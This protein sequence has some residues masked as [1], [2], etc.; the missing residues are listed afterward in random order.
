MTTSLV[1]N[2][3]ELGR[4]VQNHLNNGWT[5]Y[6]SLFILGLV[7]ITAFPKR[8]LSHHTIKSKLIK[9]EVTKVLN[10]LNLQVAGTALGA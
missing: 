9:K 1:P 5:F 6:I 4:T 3:L 2:G 8:I 10:N 7:V